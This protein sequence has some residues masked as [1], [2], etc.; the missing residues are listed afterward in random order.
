MDGLKVDVYWNL[1]KKCY[2][3]RHKGKVIAHLNNVLLRDVEWI[4]QPAGRERVLREKRKNVHAFA[5]GY[6]VQDFS[7]GSGCYTT[8][9]PYKGP[10][11]FQI[12][13]IRHY[14][15]YKS[16][17]VCMIRGWGRNGERVPEV[18]SDPVSEITLKEVRNG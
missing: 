3:V 11:F 14:P 8:Y 10:F 12:R 5:R 17:T 18:W 9:N 16:D 2:S 7:M 15:V 1:H 6:Y 13:G 4:V